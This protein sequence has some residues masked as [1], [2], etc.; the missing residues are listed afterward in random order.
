M[1]LLFC[2]SPSALISALSEAVL[3][4]YVFRSFSILPGLLAHFTGQ[5]SNTAPPSNPEEVGRSDLLVAVGGEWKG[6]VGLGR[7]RS[8]TSL[9][10]QEAYPDCS[11]RLEFSF[12]FLT[13]W[14]PS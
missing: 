3:K 2:E 7:T 10:L 1:E 5:F 12:L 6:Q 13:P 11:P 4:F 14:C 9:S 8:S